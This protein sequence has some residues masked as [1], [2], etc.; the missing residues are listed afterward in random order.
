MGKSIPPVSKFMTTMPHSV[1]VDQPLAKAQ[2]LMRE[3]HIRHLP[4][5]R[6]GQLE[7]V[8]T[9]R[10]IALIGALKDINLQTARVEDAMTTEVYAVAPDAPLDRVAAEM[11]EHKYG[12]AV[13][14]QNGHV[15]GIFTMV[16]ACSALAELLK[17][18]L[19][20]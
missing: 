5:L 10:D 3:H 17:S 19:G 16:D 18:R 14:V 9:D 1:G 8:V 7:G 4:V 20:K 2:Q 13:V 6:G 12:S 15:V 11:A